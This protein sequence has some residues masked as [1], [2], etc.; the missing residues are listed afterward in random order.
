MFS[1]HARPPRLHRRALCARTSSPTS[2]IA[3]LDDLGGVLL[4]PLARWADFRIRRGRGELARRHRRQ[5]RLRLLSSRADRATCPAW[6]FEKIQGHPVHVASFGPVR[7]VAPVGLRTTRAPVSGPPVSCPPR[8]SDHDAVK[9]LRRGSVLAHSVIGPARSAHRAGAVRFARRVPMAT[10]RIDEAAASSFARRR[11]PPCCRLPEFA[12]PG[13]V[14]HRARLAHR[15]GEQQ[16]LRRY[17][18]PLP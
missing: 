15:R 1:T 5:R 11:R 13:R 8:S 9:S 12:I 7:Q 14:R 16:T 6:S 17:N 4:G 18:F 2:S 10:A 3:V